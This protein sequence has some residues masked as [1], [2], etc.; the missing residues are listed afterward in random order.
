MDAFSLGRLAAKPSLDK[1]ELVGVRVPDA[2]RTPPLHEF[3]VAAEMSGPVAHRVI[4]GLVDDT[5]VV[6]AVFI[7]GMDVDQELAGARPVDL[8]GLVRAEEDFGVLHGYIS[9]TGPMPGGLISALW[10]CGHIQ[11]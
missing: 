8:A 2:V 4:A 5:A 9:T 3:T 11:P 10:Q 7:D 6:D 1:G